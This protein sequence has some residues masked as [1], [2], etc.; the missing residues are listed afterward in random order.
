MSDQYIFD[1]HC[2]MEEGYVKSQE[3]RQYKE[4]SPEWRAIERDRQELQHQQDTRKREA[5]TVFAALNGW[6]SSKREFTPETIGKHHDGRRGSMFELRPKI[7]D[8]M[9]GQFFDHQ[10]YYRKDKRCAAIVTEPYLGEM[11]VRLEHLRPQLHQ[12]NLDLFL[13]PD[14]LASFWFPGN[15]RFIVIAAQG[16]VIE[17]LPEQDGSLVYLW[18]I[19]PE[20]KQVTSEARAEMLAEFKY[21]VEN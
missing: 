9:L 19:T 3:A 15:T 14:P 4:G 18:G 11:T 5:R 2:L 1:I 6:K 13:P 17:W 12:L 16:S 20:G 21:G 8:D 7:H 10:H